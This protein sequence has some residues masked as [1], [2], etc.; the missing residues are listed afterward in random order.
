[1]AL[2]DQ[3]AEL[4]MDPSTSKQGPS[5]RPQR[6]FARGWEAL[7]ELWAVLRPCRFSLFVIAA[8]G[9][10]LLATP[11]GREI[12][13]RLP[14]EPF[15]WRGFW[16]HLCIFV[17]AFE[18]WYW[19]RLLLSILFSGDLKH[20]LGNRK[21]S[22]WQSKC[23][24]HAPRV[25]AILA[26]AVP[27]IALLFAGT[28]VHF[29]IA[30]ATGIAFYVGLALRRW[31]TDEILKR[32]DNMRVHKWLGDKSMQYMRLG[33]LPRLSL[34]VLGLSVL[35]SLA[36][37]AFVFFDP[38]TF[39]W[40]LGAAAVPFLGFALIV[41]VGS[42]A[43]YYCHRLVA[44]DRPRSDRSLPAVTILAAWAV[45]G[46]LLADNHAVRVLDATP[47]L[48]T[49]FGTAIEDWYKSAREV[50]GREDPPL[51]IISAAGGGLRAAYWTA[52]VLGALQD[53]DPDFARYVFAISGVSGGSLGATVFVALLAEPPERLTQTGACPPGS[54]QRGATE[55]LAQ[56]VL[57]R[58]FLA[59]TTAGLLFV[60]LVH[61]FAPI[62]P[63]GHDRA[64]ALE[65]S[66]ERAW[67]AAGLSEQAWTEEGFTRIWSRGRNPLPALLLNGVHVATGK[68]IVTSNLRIGGI[69]LTDTYDV[70]DDMLGADIPVS[71]AAHN[72]A[73]FT[74]VSP[75]GTLLEAG[76]GTPRGRIVDG[77]YFENFG[78]ATA[79]ETLRA[80]K[81]QLRAAGMR[82]NK[83]RPFLIQISNDPKVEEYVPGKTASAPAAMHESIWCRNELSSPICALLK[84]RDS[85]GTLAYKQFLEEADGADWAHFRLCR[86]VMEPALGWVLANASTEMMQE[87]VRDDTCGNREALEKVLAAIKR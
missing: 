56:S 7:R 11:Q 2:P 15:W 66:W 19:S 26:Y 8:G 76:S 18:S 27:C 20:D 77:G 58:D 16:F 5:T 10:F 45:I 70:F 78:A 38:V 53:R 40:V 17:W 59:P 87:L 85:R 28:T 86:E 4:P 71:T 72:S 32:T 14:D 82:R 62:F 13:V 80:A 37:T 60:D 81:R 79:R 24:T 52:T 61:W 75:A 23:V 41:P 25:M 54:T 50:S 12:A 3:A 22:A 48:R 63:H 1:M 73:R 42:L 68:R 55:C 47:P 74:F 9:V 39:G 65:K 44:D 84:T 29:L 30:A 33:D 69:P 31:V 49:E 67:A 83:M 46:G 64:A 6:R 51:I 36:C 57:A 21:L 43:V 34:W 35:L